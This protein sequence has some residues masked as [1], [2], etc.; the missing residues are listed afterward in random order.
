[1]QNA[2]KE[3][4]DVRRMENVFDVNYTL[5]RLKR[6]KH[7]SSSGL[8]FTN[9]W[10]VLPTSRLGYYAVKPMKSA[11]YWLSNN[12]KLLAKLLM[13]DLDLMFICI[14]A[15]LTSNVYMDIC[16]PDRTWL[17]SLNRFWLTI[18]SLLTVSLCMCRKWVKKRPV[19]GMACSETDI[20][21]KLI[22][23]RADPSER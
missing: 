12:Q 18:P 16:K 7:S 4:L 6:R 23:A 19:H 14:Y 5:E 20:V 9:V 10:S 1:M 8:W 3:W 2:Q 15:N 17:P 13:K 21:G 11:V 22:S